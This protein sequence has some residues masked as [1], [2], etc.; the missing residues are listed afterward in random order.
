MEE[1][2]SGFHVGKK[3]AIPPMAYRGGL[4]GGHAHFRAS[5]AWQEVC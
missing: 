3:R 1:K 2:F 4:L 5:H